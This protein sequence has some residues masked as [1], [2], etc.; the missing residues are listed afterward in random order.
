MD[1]LD[2][3]VAIV[4]GAAR[5][6]GRAYAKRLAALGA[7]LAV[8]DI[9]LRSFE[10]FKAEAKDMTGDNTVA[11]IEA[12]GGAALGIEVD[13]R[14]TTAV[15][16][17]VGRVCKEWGRVDVLVA[18]AGGGR[19]RPMDTKA[20][21][22]DP[23]LLRL[24]TE[25]NLFGTVYS[26]NAVAPIMKQQRSGKIITV[27]SIAGTAPAA[28]G[29]YAH[30]GA[31]KAAIAHYTR[32][33]AQDLGPFGITVNCIA[34]GVIA[35]GRIMATMIPGSSQSNRDRA[36]LVALHRLGTV[37]DCARVVEFLATDLSDYV[38]GAVIPIDGGL[39]RG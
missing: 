28:D 32:Y 16:A 10:E 25:M 12:A 5:G 3:K 27:S 34:P 33:L 8:A 14:D 23:E 7:K 39:V 15:E 37:E 38:T 35:T 29:G 11:E 26:C 6:L 24:V 20:S 19:G 30:Y 18:N 21:S 31:A 2:G 22:L 36:E 4:T 17:M 1:K 13:V 9:N